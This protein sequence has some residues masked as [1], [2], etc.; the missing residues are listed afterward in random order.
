MIELIF[1]QITRRHGRIL[2]DGNGGR[3]EMSQEQFEERNI[4]TRQE[5][6]TEVLSLQLL[7]SKEEFLTPKMYANN[8]LDEESD[9]GYI[10][11]QAI[12]NARSLDIYDL[13]PD[14]T[15]IQVRRRAFSCQSQDELL[16]D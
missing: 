4:W 14:K 2:E 10:V 11:L 15:I 1:V 6:N 8:V 12:R 7:N 16:T 5:H 3:V 9:V 13:M